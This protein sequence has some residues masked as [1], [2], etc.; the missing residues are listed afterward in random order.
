MNSRELINKWIFASLSG[1]EGFEGKVARVVPASLPGAEYPI[2]TYQ[3]QNFRDIEY[4]NGK[5]YVSEAVIAVKIW[6]RNKGFDAID[7]V[8]DI[9]PDVLLSQNGRTFEGHNIEYVERISM[10]DDFEAADNEY[11][12][13]GVMEFRVGFNCLGGL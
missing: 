10:S 3:F 2:I 11:Y 4:G 7:G 6:D 12:C 1:I 13:I 5:K 9:L 8:L